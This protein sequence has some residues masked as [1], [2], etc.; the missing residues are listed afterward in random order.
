MGWLGRSGQNWVQ[1]GR[2]RE[3]RRRRYRSIFVR[4]GPFVPTDRAGGETLRA[5]PGERRSA[6]EGWLFWL[7][8]ALVL[9]PLV[10]SAVH[11]LGEGNFHNLGDTAG[12]EMRTRDVGHHVVLLGLWSRSDWNHPGPA[13]FYLLALPYRLAGSNPS[14]SQLGALLINGAAV[15]GMAVV[16]RRRGGLALSVFTL[17]GCGIL[18]HALKPAFWGDVWNPFM[19]VLPFGVLV[20]LCWSIACD[21]VWAL[22]IAAGVASFCI[23]THVGYAPLALPLFGGAVL[24]LAVR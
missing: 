23:Q 6:P 1:C 14:G 7:A 21:D 2:P 15:L 9:L 12:I 8:V 24:V 4:Y 18:L 10:A 13:L 22:P 16:A 20:L 17:L 19:P 5:D 3:G 11:V